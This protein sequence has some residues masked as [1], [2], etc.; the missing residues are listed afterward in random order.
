VDHRQAD[1][2]ALPTG[3]GPE[4]DNAVRVAGRRLLAAVMV[5]GPLTQVVAILVLPWIG[6]DDYVSAVRASADRYPTYAWLGLAGAL[7]LAPAAIGVGLAVWRTRPG[8]ALAG[9]ILTVPGLL[10][11]DGNPEDL[12]Y[13]ANGAGVSADTTRTMLDHL[14]TLPASGPVGFYAFT[15]AFAFGGVVLGIGIIRSDSAPRWAGASLVVAGLVG[16]AGSFINLG[17]LIFGGV[18][19]LVLVAFTGCA[20]RT[21]R[22]QRS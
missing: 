19:T 15:V 14:G 4:R 12:I 6:S 1:S 9:L 3:S 22:T 10:N 5:I 2:V 20:I 7:T 21:A 13:A 17:A 8:W 11:P 18:W 16:V